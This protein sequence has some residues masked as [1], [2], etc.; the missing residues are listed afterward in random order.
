MSRTC[1]CTDDEGWRESIQEMATSMA[2]ELFERMD[3]QGVCQI[4]RRDIVARLVI[5]HTRYLEDVTLPELLERVTEMS[6][7]AH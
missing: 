7:E 4:G 6:R 2:D 1:R 3:E 5:E